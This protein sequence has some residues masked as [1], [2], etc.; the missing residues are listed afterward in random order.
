MTLSKEID[1]AIVLAE[2]LL[3]SGSSLMNAIKA[4][5]DF[6][7][8]SNSG[9]FVH[10]ELVKP[11]EPLKVFTYSPKWRWSSAIGYFDGRA[12]HLNLRKLPVM[13]VQDIASNL[14]HEYCHGRGFNHG[15]GAT[16]NYKTEEKVKFSVPYFVSA[17]V[18]SYKADA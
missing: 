12:T 7:Y 4:K 18:S 14:C 2:T 3:T 16:A 15:T 5:Q 11:G 8:N 6:K 1:A 10:W 17:F 9:E 13:S